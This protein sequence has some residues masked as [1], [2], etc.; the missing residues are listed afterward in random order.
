MSKA[1]LFGIFLELRE[2][3]RAIETANGHADLLSMILLE[4]RET[5]VK[6]QPDMFIQ[7]SEA[8]ECKYV[9]LTAIDQVS[10]EKLH[11]QLATVTFIKAVSALMKNVNVK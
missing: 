8:E 5:V 9:L 10:F 1:E 6:I 4:A 3:L 2:H 7:P 11:P